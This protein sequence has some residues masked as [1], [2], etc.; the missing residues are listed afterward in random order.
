MAFF[1]DLH[2]AFSA[3]LSLT[4]RRIARWIW[5]RIIDLANLLKVIVLFT[6]FIFVAAF[7]H[8]LTYSQTSLLR[9]L[10]WLGVVLFLAFILATIAAHFLMVNDDAPPEAPVVW[11]VGLI[12]TVSCLIVI[13]RVHYKFQSPPLAGIHTLPDTIASAFH[14][15]EKSR[16]INDFQTQPREWK[17]IHTSAV[18][19]KDKDVHLNMWVQAVYSTPSDTILEVEC[20]TWSDSESAKLDG[21]SEAYLVDQYGHKYD[22]REDRG[23]YGPFSNNRTINGS[24]I[25]RWSLVFPRVANDAVALKLKHPQFDDVDVKFESAPILI[26]PSNHQDIHK[27]EQT[28]DTTSPHASARVPFVACK[29]E[30]QAGPIP[31]PD[32][33]PNGIWI[34]AEAA[35][36]LAYYKSGASSGVLGPRGWRCYGSSASSGSGMT[37]TPEPIDEDFGSNPK[38]RDGAAIH[39]DWSYGYTFGRF[40]VAKVIARVFPTQK[41]F[42]QSV[43]DEQSYPASAFPFGAYAHDVLKYKSDQV[44]EYSTPPDSEGLG[45]MNGMHPNNESIDGVAILYSKTPPRPGDWNNRVELLLVSVRLPPEM[46]DLKSQI[47]AYEETARELPGR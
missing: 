12:L 28:P 22:L 8:E 45:T 43:I 23:E 10:G 32:E 11:F 42:A 37:V 18:T 34:E 38:W 4:Y 41:A 21:A 20:K 25:Y 46:K 1:E 24:E 31:L 9:V 5:R 2:A 33:P 36:E 40:F 30:G 27:T 44:V 26:T 15:P 29:S 35:R 47:I 39:I 6:P 13:M 16:S 14:K 19:A 3:A 17:T 7:C